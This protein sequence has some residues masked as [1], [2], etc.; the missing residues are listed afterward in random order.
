MKKIIATVTGFLLTLSS[1][2]VASA[3]FFAT[4]WGPTSSLYRFNPT[5]R[6]ATL[7]GSTGQPDMIGLVVDTDST[8][9]AM[10]EQSNSALFKLNPTTGAATLIG[11]TGF[12]LQEGDMTID[13]V[14][15]KMYVSDGIGDKLYTIDKNTGAATLIGAFGALGRDVSGLQF[16]NGILYGY[17]LNDS[18]PDTLL[19]IDPT[20]GAATLVGVSGTNLG[21]IAGMGKD[22]VSGITYVAGPLSAFG[23]DNELYSLNLTTGAATD[24]GAITGFQFSVSGF[25]V[26]GNPAILT[27]PEPASLGVLGFLGIASVCGYRWRKRKQAAP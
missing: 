17:A 16:I 13:P 9:Y 18:N 26:A 23:S 5:T 2:N 25:S 27:A 8:I 20:T 24:L 7:I 1:A 10:S 11:H 12:N 6:V 19:K 21:V 15:G 22:P 3:D 4:D 14:S